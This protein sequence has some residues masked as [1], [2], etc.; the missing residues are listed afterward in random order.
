MGPLSPLPE[1]QQ[2]RFLREAALGVPP[3][4]SVAGKNAKV[5]RR[6]PPVELAIDTTSMGEIAEENAKPAPRHLATKV[7][8]LHKLGTM[9]KIKTA[10]IPSGVGRRIG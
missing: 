10:W 9:M 6:P 7:G 5:T 4:G 3:S 2:A 8:G 1:L